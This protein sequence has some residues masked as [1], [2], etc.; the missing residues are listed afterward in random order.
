MLN[1]LITVRS[2]CSHKLGGATEHLIDGSER[3]IC[4]LSFKFQSPLLL[5][6]AVRYQSVSVSRLACRTIVII[7]T[8]SFIAIFNNYLLYE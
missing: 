5:K 2:A 4:Q 1:D 7:I 3:R 6:R 8:E